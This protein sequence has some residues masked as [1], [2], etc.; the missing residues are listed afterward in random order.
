MDLVTD[1]VWFDNHPKM[2]FIQ[3]ESKYKVEEILSSFRAPEVRVNNQLVQIKRAGECLQLEWEALIPST[4]DEL[5]EGSNDQECES[6]P[7]PPLDIIINQNIPLNVP[8]ISET[9]RVPDPAE[10]LSTQ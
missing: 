2:G 9:S 3:F 8:N 4:L 1:F 7:N 10:F 6:Y 5:Q